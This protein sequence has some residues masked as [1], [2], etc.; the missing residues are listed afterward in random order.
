MPP[1]DAQPPG[2]SRGSRCRHAPTPGP[3]CD[4]PHHPF[5]KTQASL[6]PAWGGEAGRPPLCAGASRTA[7]TSST[8]WVR[9]LREAASLSEPDARPPELQTSKDART[10]V[11][12][13]GRDRERAVRPPSALLGRLRS[14][15]L[16][17]ASG[18]AQWRCRR[19][20]LHA[21]RA[22]VRTCMR[23]RSASAPR[24]EVRCQGAA[25]TG[26]CPVKLDGRRF[27]LDAGAAAAAAGRG[28]RGVISA[29]RQRRWEC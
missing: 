12:G 19:A 18:G 28:V 1:G 6:C 10:E 3:R 7:R 13:R 11:T 27:R 16:G 26:V 5:S 23:V 14:R 20:P 15:A 21:T 24:P 17:G 29:P 25:D 9:K 4:L 22:P 8:R 2:V